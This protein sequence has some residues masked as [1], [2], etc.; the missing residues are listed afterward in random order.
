MPEISTLIVSLEGK[1]DGMQ[2]QIAQLSRVIESLARIEENMANQK[3]DV[4]GFGHRLDAHEKRMREME[5][6]L[7]VNANQGGTTARWMERIIAF[8]IIAALGAFNLFKK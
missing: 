2:R 6:R 7:A 4:D 3:D 8:M 1:V 5:I